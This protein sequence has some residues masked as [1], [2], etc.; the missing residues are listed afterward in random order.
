MRFAVLHHSAH[1]TFRR[2]LRKIQITKPT[3]AFVYLHRRLAWPTIGK[4]RMVNG[5]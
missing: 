2:E 1:I 5:K 4:S 3:Y